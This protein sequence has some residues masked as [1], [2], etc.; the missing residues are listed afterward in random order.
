M[1][2]NVDNKILVTADALKVGDRIPG[3]GAG[4]HVVTQAHKAWDA[5]LGDCMFLVV[6]Q[7]P[8][9]RFDEQEY[10]YRTY[11]KVWVLTRQ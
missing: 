4:I 6:R 10:Y 5:L 3:K 1:I 11:D 2:A 7:E 8:Q 9:E